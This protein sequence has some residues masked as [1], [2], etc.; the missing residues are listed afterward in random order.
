MKDTKGYY[1]QIANWVILEQEHMNAHCVH[2]K[3]QTL[4]S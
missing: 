3:L 1:V 4:L 2:Q